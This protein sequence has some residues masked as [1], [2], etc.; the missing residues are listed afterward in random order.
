MPFLANDLENTQNTESPFLSK[1][2]ISQWEVWYIL[3]LYSRILCRVT[4][5]I[6][7]DRNSGYGV[8]RVSVYKKY[9]LLLLSEKAVLHFPNVNIS[10]NAYFL[11]VNGFW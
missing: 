9:L 7:L 8:K 2:V 3:S 6:T 4:E 10:I 5:H 1:G 11:L